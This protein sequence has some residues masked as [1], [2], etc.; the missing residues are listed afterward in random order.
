M[1]KWKIKKGRDE[2]K[3]PSDKVTDGNP[4]CFAACLYRGTENGWPSEIP[5]PAKQITAEDE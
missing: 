5:P 1:E 2:N 4:H 3:E